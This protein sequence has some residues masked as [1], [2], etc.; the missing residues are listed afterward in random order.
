M[1]AWVAHLRGYLLLTLAFA[2]AIGGV[3]FLS[4]RPDPRPVQLATP[5]AR[6]SATLRPSATPAGLVVEV[7]GAVANPGLFHLADGARVDDAIRAAGGASAEADLTGVNLARKLSDGELLSVPRLGQPTSAAAAPTGRAGQPARAA[8]A[9]RAPTA[10]AVLSVNINTASA[11]ELNRLP[12]IGPAL[13]QRIIDY[14]QVNGPYGKPEDVMKVKGI[15]PAEFGAIKD[16]IV[17][18]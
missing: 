10:A 11:D 7:S 14:R 16:K 18:Q 15:G 13:A 9:T 1:N 3:Y 12:G 2:V 8:T 4:R 6:P 17:V 5:F